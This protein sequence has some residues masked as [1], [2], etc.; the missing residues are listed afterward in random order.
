MTEEPET[1]RRL[2]ALV[3]DLEATCDEDG[4]L[5]FPREILQIA[6][7]VHA[8]EGPLA[9]L[10]GQRFEQLVLPTNLDGLTPFCQQLTGLTPDRVRER[11]VP[12]AVAHARLLGW[13]IAVGLLAPSPTRRG[14]GSAEQLRL[15]KRHR[16]IFATYGSCDLAEMWPEQCR[17]S[18]LTVAPWFRSWV[19]VAKMFELCTGRHRLVS[20]RQATRTL[21]LY[22]SIF[23][24]S[25]AHDALADA[26][27]CS[28]VL[29]AMEDGF[30]YRTYPVNRIPPEAV[31]DRTGET[32]EVPC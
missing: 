7:V 14:C 30:G 6:V 32:V 28:A 31:G 23:G 5:P 12:F 24:A 9:S 15:R 18:R 21:L 10:H 17:L 29:G 4:P 8:P 13:L 19:D 20:L 25:A 2:C 27:A 26:I 1:I 11:G 22:D 16:W 3:L